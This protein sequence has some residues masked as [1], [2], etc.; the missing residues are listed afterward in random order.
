M[1]S[2]HVCRHVGGMGKSMPMLM[3]CPVPGRIPGLVPARTWINRERTI[4]AGMRIGVLLV[5]RRG[6]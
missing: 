5:T 6:C 1:I 2:T 3:C 4:S